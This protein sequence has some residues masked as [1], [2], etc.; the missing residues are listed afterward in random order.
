MDVVVTGSSG[1]IGSRLVQTLRE[2]GHQVVRLVRSGGGPDTARWDL[3]AGT[4][5]AAALDGAGAVVHLAGESIASSRWTDAQKARI[6]G[7]RVKGTTLLAETLAGLSSPP[8][9]FL[10][11]SAVGYYGETGDTAVDESGPA[12]DDFPSLVAQRWEACA[13]PAIDAGVATAFLR[14]GVVLDADGGALKAQLL[15]FKLGLGGRAG[16]GRQ[17]LSWITLDDHV[18]ATI[19]LL[20]AG[21]TGPVNL[22]APN[23]CTNAEFAKALG[24]ALGRPTFIIPMFG[25]RVLYGRELADSLLL[26]SQRVVPGALNGI[27]FAFDHPDIDGALRSVLDAA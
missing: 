11:G 23:P 18:R 14:T 8:S 10:S 4:I 2:Q 1:L 20:T 5:E 24:A 21:L 25:P 19:T 26:T 6:M 16:S 9:V 27:G 7:S 17:Y 22:T 13:Q 12:G 3:D 15:P